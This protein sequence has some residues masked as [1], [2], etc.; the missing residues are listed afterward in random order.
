MP[1]NIIDKVF[2]K[3]AAEDGF[4]SKF[5][6][7]VTEYLKKADIDHII[8]VAQYPKVL[9][10]CYGDSGNIITLMLS[11]LVKIV[12][13]QQSTLDEKDFEEFKRTIIDALK[14]ELN[15]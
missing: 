15:I 6:H 4:K 13:D 5:T 3:S 12:N 7:H 11:V 8:I 1:K 14:H 9:A 10:H 2:G